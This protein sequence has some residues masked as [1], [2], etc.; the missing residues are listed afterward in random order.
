MAEPNAGSFPDELDPEE[1][2]AERT[3]EVRDAQLTE[4][5]DRESEVA[6]LGLILADENTRDF[7]WRVL[8]KCSVFASTYNRAFSDMAYAE[9]RRSIG[10]WLLN[11]IAEA[12]PDALLTM[13]T[14]ANRLAAQ[15][16]R[17]RRL[18]TLRGRRAPANR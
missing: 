10:L 7:V 3:K 8:A 2:E 4:A 18:K 9:G 12:N 15:E 5:M 14:K 13:Q 17:A 16:A 6:Q 1:H 11:E